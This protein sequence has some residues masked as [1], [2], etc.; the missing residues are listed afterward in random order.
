MASVES[1]IDSSSSNVGD[2]IDSLNAAWTFGGS[3]P[4]YFDS[5]VS[6]SVPKYQDGHDI[7]LALSDFFINE[8]SIVYELGSSTGALTRKLAGHHNKGA[9][10]IGIDIEEAIIRQANHL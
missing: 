5:H 6:K 2:G 4:Q 9:K 8:Q 10:F 7:V 1:I 3:T